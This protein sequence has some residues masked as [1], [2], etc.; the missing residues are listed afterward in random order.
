MAKEKKLLKN[1][2]IWQWIVLNCFLVLFGASIIVNSTYIP[3]YLALKSR[4]D[5]TLQIN[6]KAYN[7]INNTHTRL[8]FFQYQTM[9]ATLGDLMAHYQDTY[10]L[11]GGGA[12]GRSL[13]FITYY[14]ED[15]EENITLEG[16]WAPKKPYWAIYLNGSLSPV[17][18]D[19]LYLQM[20]DKVE[21][22][23]TLS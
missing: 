22:F 20:N 15:K 13:K 14:D 3:K 17:G 10:T 21:L 6:I 23:Y 11:E 1:K 7:D 19:G 18:I 16:S 9:M 5:N 8:F 2:K 4:S 12:L